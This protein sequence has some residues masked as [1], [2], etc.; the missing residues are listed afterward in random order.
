MEDRALK[1]IHTIRGVTWVWF[2]M[3]KA[4]E[5]DKLLNS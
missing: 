3:E 2:D 5:A 4:M 1:R